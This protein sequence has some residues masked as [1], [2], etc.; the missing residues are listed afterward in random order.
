MVDFN[1]MIKVGEYPPA[2]NLI[3]QS[4]LPCGPIYQS[5]GLRVH[6]EKRHPNCLTYL[7]CISE[8]L[9]FPDYIGKNP[10]EPNSIEIVKHYDANMM[11]A[12]KLDLKNGYLFIASL[13]AISDGKLKK[14]LDSG[15]LKRVNS[16][17]S[18]LDASFKK[19]Y[20]ESIKE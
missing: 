6:I 18:D 20:N 1:K 17:F 4:D 2:F 15:R 7:S 5:K 16:L 8:I 10:K 3:T 11:V 14:H 19:P 13:Y 9:E 12:V